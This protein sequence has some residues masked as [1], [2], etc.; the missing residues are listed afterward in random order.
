MFAGVLAQ[1]D[2][3]LDHEEH[4]RRCQALRKEFASIEEDIRFEL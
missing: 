1:V 3:M 4:E 2:E